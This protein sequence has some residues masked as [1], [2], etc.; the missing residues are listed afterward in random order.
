VLRF[1][2]IDDLLIGATAAQKD[3]FRNVGAAWVFAVY[4]KRLTDA[5]GTLRALLYTD[6]GNSV[7]RFASF[8]GSSNTGLANTPRLLCKRLDG[9]AV[10]GINP[11][12]AV[13]GAYVMAL[14][15]VEYTSR[16]GQIQINAAVV[17]SSS[18]LTTTPG[19]T[20]DTTAQTPLVIGAT[21]FQTSGFADMDLAAMVVGNTSPS[22]ADMDRLNG[23]AAHKYGLTASLPSG[24]PYK[25]TAP[26][27]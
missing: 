7:A 24:H 20:S 25:T 21:T 14:H 15:G 27:V 18:T 19:N 12:G 8:L 1:D 4:R 26:T 10:S 22:A 16:S 11:S 2:G 13:V 9:E 23:W 6:A 3:I 5:D 17:A